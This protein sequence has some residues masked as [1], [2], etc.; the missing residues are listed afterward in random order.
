MDIAFVGVVEEVEEDGEASWT[1]KRLLL[2]WQRES[3][4]IT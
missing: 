4:G 2:Y 1:F 3:T